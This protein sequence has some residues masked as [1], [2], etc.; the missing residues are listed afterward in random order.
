MTSRTFVI[1]VVAIAL[2]VGG[3]VY[4]HRPRGGPASRLPQT[5]HQVP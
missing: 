4:L 3:I 5:L 1:V 2:L